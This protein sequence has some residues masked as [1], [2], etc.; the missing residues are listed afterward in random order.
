MSRE[1]ERALERQLA[2]IE[3]FDTPSSQLWM[4]L[5]TQMYQHQMA[6]DPLRRRIENTLQT[7]ETFYVS[8]EMTK[9]VEVAADREALG[10]PVLEEHVPFTKKG[11]VYFQRPITIWQVTLDHLEHPVTQAVK[12]SAMLWSY[13]PASVVTVEGGEAGPARDGVTI[14]MFGHDD[15]LQVYHDW[16]KDPASADREM[17]RSMIGE[18]PEDDWPEKVRE[19]RM[20]YGVDEYRSPPIGL[21]EAGSWAQGIEWAESDD[22][23]QMLEE[24]VDQLSAQ[25]RLEYLHNSTN[26]WHGV[27][28]Q[29]RVLFSLWS[30][31]A[32]PIATPRSERPSRAYRR[33][34]EQRVTAAPNYGDVRVVTL[35]RSSGGGQ[36]EDVDD[37][38]GPEWSH[39]WVV[40]GHW[41][42]QWYASEGVHRMIWISP[43]VKGPVDKPLIVKDRVFE[44]VR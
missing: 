39:R 43:F 12:C 21:M 30:L 18:V 27:A 7:A 4:S 17:V 24:P 34:W 42:K 40:R 29:R 31:M 15:Q 28:V 33:R 10:D 26:V 20:L 5:F 25:S 41:R 35:R 3:W 22:L 8:E 23:T 16:L 9:L 11:F 38:F 36:T 1:W 32:Q 6:P 44:V 19:Y 37:E 2:L 13:E 14:W